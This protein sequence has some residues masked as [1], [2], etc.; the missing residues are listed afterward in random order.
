MPAMYINAEQK[1]WDVIL[2]YMMF[3]YNAQCSRPPRWRLLGSFMAGAQRPPS[4]LCCWTS[5]MSTTLASPPI[6]SMQKK[7][8]DF[9]SCGS[10]ISSAL[11]LDATTCADAMQNASP[12][13]MYECGL[14]FATVDWVNS[15]CATISAH[16]EFLILKNLPTKLFP[17]ELQRHSGAVHTQK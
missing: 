2:L 6:S 14:W 9:P 8:Y 17:I 1:T 3:A 13:T 11:I 15:I 7:P 4:V 5:P 10:S 12:V 16:K